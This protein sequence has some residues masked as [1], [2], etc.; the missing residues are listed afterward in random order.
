MILPEEYGSRGVKLIT[1]LHLV[2]RLRMSG[3]ILLLPLYV[4]KARRER[5]LPLRC[6]TEGSDSSPGSLCEVF[7]APDV[8]Y[9]SGDSGEEMC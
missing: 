4:L 5:V 8:V 2:P 3:D 9:S 7:S 1:H 6:N